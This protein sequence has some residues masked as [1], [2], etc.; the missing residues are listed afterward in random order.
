MT[1]IHSGIMFNFYPGLS[2]VQDQSEE[3]DSSALTNELYH[4]AT[5]P[6]HIPLSHSSKKKLHS[7]LLKVDI[8]RLIWWYSQKCVRICISRPR[9][10]LLHIIA[11][12]HPDWQP[13]NSGIHT[14]YHK[15]KLFRWLYKS[16]TKILTC[17]CCSQGR[18]P[19]CF[20]QCHERLPSL[21]PGQ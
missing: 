21:L 15:Q 13:M 3:S 19:Q 4:E 1:K 16:M 7:N 14:L 2:H 12:W 6:S 20:S 10:N 11:D 9:E 8:W 18:H 5:L 17:S